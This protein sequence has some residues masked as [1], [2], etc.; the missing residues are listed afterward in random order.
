MLN[1]GAFNVYIHNV[2]LRI[3][4]NFLETKENI[5]IST[6]PFYHI[7]LDRLTE[8]PICKIFAKFFWELAILKN[9]V[10]RVGHFEFFFSKKINFFLLF[11]HKNMSKFIG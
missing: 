5:K 10:F 11:P 4:R 2:I 6:H 9:V 1:H 3:A 8:G 7:N